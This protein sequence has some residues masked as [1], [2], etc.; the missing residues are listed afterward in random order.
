MSFRHDIDEE[1]ERKESRLNKAKEMIR[2]A[3]E[4]EAPDHVKRRLEIELQEAYEDMGYS[5]G[6]I[7]GFRDF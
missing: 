1:F 5:E 7:G 2:L 3:S 4:L 6:H